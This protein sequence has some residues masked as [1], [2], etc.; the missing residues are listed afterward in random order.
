MADH[1]PTT[2]NGWT[3]DFRDYIKELGRTF[4]TDQI[5][6]TEADQIKDRMR[7]ACARYFEMRMREWTEQP[8][9]K[10]QPVLIEPLPTD[11]VWNYRSDDKSWE[12][13]AGRSGYALVRDGVEIWHIRTGMS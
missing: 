2:R 3:F 8:D 10:E 9:G 1:A 11:E 5:T 7:Q 13:L 6:G 12:N 4:L